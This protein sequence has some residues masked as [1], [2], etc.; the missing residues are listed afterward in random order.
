MILAA[1]GALSFLGLTLSG[2][3]VKL[4][5]DPYTNPTGQHET[6]TEPSILAQGQ[7]LVAAFHVARLEGGG[8]TNF[9]WASS[10]DAGA[11]WT[12]GVL[13]HASIYEGGTYESMSDPV[14]GYDAKTNTWMILGFGTNGGTR[15]VFVSRSSDGT[16]WSAPVSVYQGESPDKPWMACDNLSTSPHYGNC[17]ITFDEEGENSLVYISRSK[18]GGVTWESPKTTANRAIGIGGVPVIQPGGQVIVPTSTVDF[19]GVF[20]Y[21]SSDGGDSWSSTTPISSVQSESHGGSSYG[22]G[23]AG[24]RT[25]PMPSVVSDSSGRIYVSWF[26]CQLQPQCQAND[27]VL[28]TSQD[29]ITWSEVKA[30]APALTQAGASLIFP[31]LGVDSRTSGNQARIGVA[32]YSVEGANCVADSTQCEIFAN[33]ISSNDG[34]QTWGAPLRLGGP[35]NPDWIST[36]NRGKMIGDYTQTAYVN[37]VAFP[38]VSVGMAPG[39]K[40][41][42]Q[43]IYTASVIE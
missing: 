22:S 43:G 20:A 21:R 19:S 7:T 9:G 15:T 31:G 1:C 37:G 39:T 13:P 6:A 40:Q 16:Q 23:R 36:T 25:A 33:F 12:R 5:N 2:S 10:K 24:L 18:D 34:G 30:I 41:Y 42:Q 26:D 17:Y 14:V 28:T 11:T 29:G 27:L 8:V 3:L 4:S 35:M 38:I 32:F